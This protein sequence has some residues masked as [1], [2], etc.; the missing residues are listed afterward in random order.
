MTLRELSQPRWLLTSL[1]I[2]GA[3]LFAIGIAAERNASAHHT[4]TGTEAAN[5]TETTSGQTAPAA[6]SGGDEATHTDETTGEETTHTEVPGGE[7]TAHSETSAET[8]LGINLESD[9]LVIVAI[10]VSLAL[11]ALTWLRNRRSL[12][13]ATMAF[14]LV[15]AVFDIAEVAHQLKESRSGLAVFAAAIAL[16]HLATALVAEQRATTAPSQKRSTSPG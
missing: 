6:E 3:A 7:P 13:L 11:A 9:A 1:L 8:V 2:A 5:P 14:A 12:L 10:A 4:E 15:F 16:V